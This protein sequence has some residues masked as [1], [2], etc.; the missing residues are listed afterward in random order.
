MKVLPVALQYACFKF[1]IQLHAMVGGQTGSAAAV[2]NTPHEQ[3]LPRLKA[4][5]VAALADRQ[6]MCQEAGQSQLG[7]ITLSH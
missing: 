6:H 5:L 7:F 3:S 4:L 1:A 2:C